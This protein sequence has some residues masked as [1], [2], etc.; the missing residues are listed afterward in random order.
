MAIT[1]AQGLAAKVL[2]EQQLGE[3][4]AQS[5]TPTGAKHPSR[6]PTASTSVRVPPQRNL[7]NSLGH[8]AQTAGVA[9]RRLAFPLLLIFMVVA[10]LLV[11]GELDRRDPKLAAAPVDSSLDMVV[12]E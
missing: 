9:V 11:Q 2:A 5:R 8:L 1:K 6:H 10:F 12:F 7:F 4:R 3:L